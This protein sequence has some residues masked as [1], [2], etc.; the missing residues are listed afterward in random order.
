MT[1]QNLD[2]QMFKIIWKWSVCSS[3]IADLKL[4]YN[5]K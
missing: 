5:R 2:Y 1:S 3:D 4:L